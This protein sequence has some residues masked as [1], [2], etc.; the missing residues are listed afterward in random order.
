MKTAISRTSYLQKIVV[1][2]NIQYDLGSFD[3]DGYDFG[4]EGTIFVREKE[5]CRPDLLSAR[6]YGVMGYWWFLM[7]YN[8]ICDCWNDLKVDQAIRY[9]SLDRV[10]EFLQTVVKNDE[11]I[12][13]VDSL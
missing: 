4:D 5:L 13:I 1:D 3:P 2:G 7:W 9:P 6:V 8:G 12:E 11:N 10:R